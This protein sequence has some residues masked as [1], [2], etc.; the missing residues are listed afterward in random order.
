MLMQQAGLTRFTAALSVGALVWL[1]GWVVVTSLQ[2]GGH[3]A[4]FGNR[5]LLGVFDVVTTGVLLPVVGLLVAILVG[6]QLRPELLRQ[7]LSRE[8][9][10]LFSLWRFLLRYVAP[11]GIAAL[12]LAPLWRTAG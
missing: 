1:L 10:A 11:I 4:W 7:R 5:N 8:S 3:H 2:P 6:W 9:D 12:L